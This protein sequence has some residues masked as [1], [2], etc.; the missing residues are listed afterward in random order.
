MPLE[1][2]MHVP[3][4]ADLPLICA[5]PEFTSFTDSVRDGLQVSITP[6]LRLGGSPSIALGTETGSESSFIFRCQRSNS[7]LLV[8][9]RELLE[10]FLLNRSIRIYPW[11][12]THNHK[13]GDSLFPFFDSRVLP[14]TG[15]QGW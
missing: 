5:S 1:A 13:R 8:I 9:A 2:E 7:E 10:Q 6:N 14:T 4:S 11:P 15:K 12:G 3:S